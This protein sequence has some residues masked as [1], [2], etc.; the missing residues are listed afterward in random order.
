VFGPNTIPTTAASATSP[1]GGLTSTSMLIIG[2]LGVA[3][4]LVITKMKR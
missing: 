2:G 4:L 1:F 3:A